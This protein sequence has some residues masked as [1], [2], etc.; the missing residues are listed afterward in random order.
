VAAMTA[1]GFFRTG[2]IGWLRGDGTFVYETRQGDAMRLAGF[3]VS[4]FEIE[5]LL[6][7]IPGVADAQV[8]AVEIARA[9]RW[10]GVGV[11]PETGRRSEAEIIASVGPLL[12]PYKVPA[13][14]WF[15][16]EFPVTQ[17][18][19]GTKIQRGKLREMAIARLRASDAA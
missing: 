18:A 8:V 17:S 19:N 12:A 1:D 4:P 7:T 9:P 5:D 10:G 3:L 2:D 6:E 15:V 14:V 13:R 16:D 11:P